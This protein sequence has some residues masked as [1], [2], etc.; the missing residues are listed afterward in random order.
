MAKK[1]RQRKKIDFQKPKTTAQRKEQESTRNRMALL[2]WLAIGFLGVVYVLST[3]VFISY[4]FTGL[5]CLC[6]MSVLLFYNV[7]DWLQKK[8][9]KQVKVVRRIF[10]VCLCVGLLL[11]AVTEVFILRGSLGDPDKSC[12]YV[13]VLGCHV[14]PNGPSLT[15]LDRI[16]AAYDYLT[17]HPDVIAVV[18][19][20]QGFDEPMSE[21]Q[22]IYEHL[23]ER[24][25][26][27]DR[28]WIEDKATS[29]WENL[30]FS[31]DMI[32]ERTGTRPDTLGIISSE[33]HLFRAGL[34]AK[35]CGVVPVRIPAVTSVISQRV[36]HFMR[37]VAGV[38]YYL[39][40]G[41]NYE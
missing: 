34:Q 36:N 2:R 31:L 25:I 14:R 41:G 40:L 16:N 8:Y 32:R 30:N 28:V 13:V 9:P 3:F 35:D 23:V 29:T 4:S 12:D 15:L 10:T 22:C 19:G 11:V 33:Y 1:I 5:V 26:D 27:P 20:G 37:E 18:S 38:W 7:A 17:E 24:G 39:I 6:V 21:A